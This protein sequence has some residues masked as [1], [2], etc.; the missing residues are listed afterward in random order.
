MGSSAVAFVFVTSTAASVGFWSSLSMGSSAVAFVFVTSTA[1]SVGFWSSLSMGSSAIAFVF[2]T[3]TAASVG[4]WSSLSTGSSA[5]AFV[6][7]SS[8][9]A[10][11]TFLGPSSSV[12]D[13]CS[14]IITASPTLPG[15]G[16]PS[17]TTIVSFAANDSPSNAVSSTTTFSDWLKGSKFSIIVAVL[18]SLSPTSI[19]STPLELTPPN[20]SSIA[21]GFTMS[22]TSFFIS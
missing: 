3:S 1:A 19:S 11:S 4:F 13:I 10:S 17:A 18:I 21:T 5:V 16:S 14:I 8:L 9:A 12:I 22:T 15:I 2:I 7:S 6:F 20:P